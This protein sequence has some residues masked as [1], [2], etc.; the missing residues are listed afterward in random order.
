MNLKLI[1]LIFSMIHK[2]GLILF[3]SFWHLK[4]AS[5]WKLHR[6]SNYD[7]R[8]LQ[9]SLKYLTDFQD[10]PLWCTAL[11]TKW[12]RLWTQNIQNMTILIITIFN[13]FMIQ[14]F[15]TTWFCKSIKYFSICIFYGRYQT[16]N[17]QNDCYDEN[18]WQNFMKDFTD[19]SGLRTRLGSN[20]TEVVT[21]LS[22]KPWL[23]SSK[24]GN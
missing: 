16:T 20:S 22:W 9:R 2:K 19:R 6:M 1:F 7:L 18:N 23:L 3:D 10:R 13:P 24:T 14:T 15:M 11:S 12:T 4:K 17:Y 5:W 21:S 8:H